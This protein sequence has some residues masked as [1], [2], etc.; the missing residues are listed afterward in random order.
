VFVL[1]AY[2]SRSG[3]ARSRAGVLTLPRLDV[4]D[5]K[6][7]VG[8]TGSG[9]TTV[10]LTIPVRGTAK[11]TSRVWVDTASLSDGGSTGRAYTLKA[12]QTSLSVPLTVISDG[13]YSVDPVEYL[14]SVTAV[15]DIE[16]G[17]YVGSVEVGSTVAPPTLTV[18]DAHVDVTQ[19]ETARW[20]LRLSAP[21]RGWFSTNLSFVPPQSGAE[22]TSDQVLRSWSDA[23]LQTPRTQHGTPR[24]LSSSGALWNLEMGDLVTTA[25]VEL[26]LSGAS[27]A[28][29]DRNVSVQVEPDGVLLTEPL[30]LT[31]TVHPK[32]A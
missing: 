29:G 13:T 1:D 12:G 25:T 18:L 21:V 2:A 9:T 24:A 32:G 28:T 20:T 17:R 16:T 5:A 10:H 23:H 26:P 7:K 14:V 11:A 15:R 4:R 6:V 27:S 19:G 30:L 8:V 22:L 31:A 3:L